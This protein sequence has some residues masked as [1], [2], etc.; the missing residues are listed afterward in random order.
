MKINI[1]QAGGEP[2]YLF[3]LLNGLSKIR[4]LEVQVVGSDKTEKCC[5]E[6]KNI[7]HLNIRG[8]QD[9][10]SSIVNKIFRII[11]YYSKLILFAAKT[12]ADIFHIQWLNKFYVFD[13]TILLLYYKLLKKK[14]LF[15][16]HNIDDNGRP[17]Q[18]SS[19]INRLT[20]KFFY[21]NVDHIIVHTE[22]SKKDLLNSFSVNPEKITVIPH[23]INIRHSN[24]SIEKEQAR[25]K[26]NIA[27]NKK[28]ILFFGRMEY[29]KG[30]DILI[31]AFNQIKNKIENAYLIIAGYPSE[32]K[33]VERLDKQI[34]DS[35]SAEYYSTNYEYLSEANIANVMSAAD[36]IILPYRGIYQSGVLFLAYS[37]GLPVIASDVGNFK[38]DIQENKTGF[39]FEKENVEDLVKKIKMFFES[40]LYINQQIKRSKIKAYAEDKYSWDNIG[41]LT[42]KLYK[43]IAGD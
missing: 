40:D 16:A 38:N 42:Y 17:G 22:G 32:I 14:I 36:C 1:I 37:F 34:N 12:D 7:K 39:L 8:N 11:S 19:Y 29:Y 21:K 31:E 6:Y 30:V 15:T 25:Q 27:F 18:K 10:N 33:Y 4:G 5:S 43:N 20:I 26:Y 2:D 3:G 24:L 23:G 41:E 35:L 9:T 28:V 13:R